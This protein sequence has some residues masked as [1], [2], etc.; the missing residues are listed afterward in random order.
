MIM[1][2]MTIEYIQKGKNNWLHLQ[3]CDD[4]I[5]AVAAAKRSW[6]DLSGMKLFAVR[7]VSNKDKALYG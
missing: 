4:I 1:D 5:E 3:E 6:I 7:V 2:H